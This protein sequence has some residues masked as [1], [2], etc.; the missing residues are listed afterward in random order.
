[1]VN[2][3]WSFEQVRL[4]VINSAELSLLERFVKLCTHLFSGLRSPVSNQTVQVADWA[5]ALHNVRDA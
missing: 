3:D 1:M 2:L 5:A 4:I